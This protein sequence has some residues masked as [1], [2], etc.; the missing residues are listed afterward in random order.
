MDVFSSTIRS[1]RRRAAGGPSGMTAEH[2]R[3]VL[4]SPRSL[5]TSS[6][7][8]AQWTSCRSAEAWWGRAG[9]RVW[10]S[11]SEC[12]SRGALLSRSRLQWRRRLLLFNSV[13]NQGRWGKRGTIQSLTDLDSRATVDVGRPPTSS[14]G[15][16]CAS[17]R[18]CLTNTSSPTWTLVCPVS[19]R[20]RRPH[21]QAPPGGFGAARQDPFTWGRRTTCLRGDAGSRGSR[22][23]TITGQNLARC[24]TSVTARDSC[25]GHP[26]WPRRACAG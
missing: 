10:G 17:F 15:R 11:C 22:Q 1:A 25:T 24:W 6:L 21:L 2:L 5:L 20:P 7:C 23:P 3:L 26:D 12:W 18:C 13:D 14:W 16:H 9:H 8:C 19:A 4:E